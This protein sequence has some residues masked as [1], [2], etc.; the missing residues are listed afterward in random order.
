MKTKNILPE[1]DTNLNVSL[2]ELIPKNMSKEN[3]K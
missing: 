1:F 2:P 3:Q